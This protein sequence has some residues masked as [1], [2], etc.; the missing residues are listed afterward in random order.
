MMTSRERVMAAIEHRE[1]D[2][3]PV[4]LGG[5]RSS[6]IMAIAY[7]KLKQY[8]GISSGNIYVYDFVQ[9]LAIVEPLILERFGVDTVELGRGFALG[10]KD[11]RDWVLPDGTPCKIPSFIHPVQVNG[12][13]HI[14]ASDEGQ[15]PANLIAVQ[16][17]GS[18]YF[19]QTCFPWLTYTGDDFSNLRDAMDQ[20]MWA[21]LGS[22]PAPIG[23]DDDGLARLAAGAK[24]LRAS[25]DR[26]VIGLFGGNL[27][28]WGQFLFR[29]DN[30]LMLLAGEPRRM[31]KFLDTLVAYHLDN[32]KKFLS[33]VGPYIDILL[34]GDDLGMQHGPQISSRM[35]RAFFFPRHKLL[36]QT[37][38]R[39]ADVK[40]MLHSC[41]SVAAYIPMF[42]EAGLDILQ[43]LQTSARDM[44]PATL[45]REFGKDLC[46][47]GGACDTQHVLPCG[48]PEEVAADVR[49]RVAT[50]APGG[51][52]VFQQVHNIMADVPPEN[53]V[54]MLDA[55]N[56]VEQS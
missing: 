34:F 3:V 19:E 46:L 26:A 39:L 37:A 41:G 38:K 48:T 28:E 43:P 12:D 24:A 10:P 1:P 2:R 36:W 40:V 27:M 4:D 8:L 25:T 51:G 20:V 50:F 45:K 35:Y 47:W 11:W 17:K 52:F 56:P 9:Q 7:H 6:G 21:T 16:K 22:P 53:V 55:V 30:F 5:H 32:L 44:E 13:W 49:Q 14:Y 54:A 29:M 15:S 31:H 33:A 18:L 42:I 23:F